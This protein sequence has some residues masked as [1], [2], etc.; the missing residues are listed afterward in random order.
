LCQVHRNG[1]EAAY[2][3]YQVGGKTSTADEVKTDL[4]IVAPD[5]SVL[6]KVLGNLDNFKP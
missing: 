2:K 3:L 6:F 1:L 5:I 4:G